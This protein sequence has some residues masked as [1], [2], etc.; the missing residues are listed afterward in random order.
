[1][2]KSLKVEAI[3]VATQQPP[4]RVSLTMRCGECL[5][6]T[7]HRKFEKKCSELGHQELSEA[8]AYFTPDVTHLADV[9]P[10]LLT[11]VAK[12]T[13]SM[14]QKQVRLLMFALRQSTFA[15]KV[16]FEF[17]D[18]VAF[19][20]GQDY[21]E[22][23]VSGVVVGA[24]RSGDK[25]YIISSLSGVNRGGATCAI[26]TERVLSLKDF[27]TKRKELIK[28]NQIVA[29]KVRNSKTVI[30]ML[31]MSPTELDA[32]RKSLTAKPLYTPLSID[33]ISWE[34]TNDKKQS[35][36]SPIVIQ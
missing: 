28:A 21:L 3:P 11:L 1:M 17:G 35:S 15:K 9:S 20:I 33:H 34:G 26:E 23:Y 29:P 2:K 27:E 10:D 31:R 25:V 13:K 16:G 22:S 30:E 18:T 7:G 12:V 14:T 24:N 8:C 4:S 5:H 32:H 36:T 6:L 19:P